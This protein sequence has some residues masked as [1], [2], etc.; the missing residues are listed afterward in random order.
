[1]YSPS[2]LG[3]EGIDGYGRPVAYMMKKLNFYLGKTEFL[4]ISAPCASLTRG[5]I[6]WILYRILETS[7]PVDRSIKILFS[8]IM[9]QNRGFCR[10][11]KLTFYITE[12]L[13]Y[14]PEI[15]TLLFYI[16]F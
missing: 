8:L 1:M 15:W 3:I 6:V 14:Q 2:G 11:K 13:L 16:I 9:L 5:F 7:A 12:I 4:K 10:I